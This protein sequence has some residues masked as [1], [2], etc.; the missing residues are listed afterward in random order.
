M[1][2]YYG[3]SFP[4]GDATNAGSNQASPVITV[5]G[6]EDVDILYSISIP[7][8]LSIRHRNGP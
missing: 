6:Q 7:F 5:E 2:I 8:P 3:V 1:T 4:L